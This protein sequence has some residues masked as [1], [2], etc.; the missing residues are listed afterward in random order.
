MRPSL[1][2][3][4]DDLIDARVVCFHTW[5]LFA[6]VRDDA[7]SACIQSCNR[8]IRAQCAPVL[9]RKPAGGP[10]AGDGWERAHR[11]SCA[12]PFERCK[13]RCALTGSR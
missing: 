3:R 5:S 7:S 9:R 6:V 2:D 4:T 8:E 10:R 13:T 11:S 12:E 1:R